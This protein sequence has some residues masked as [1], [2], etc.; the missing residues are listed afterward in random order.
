M[1]NNRRFFVPVDITQLQLENVPEGI[2]DILAE[3][4]AEKEKSQKN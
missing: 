3:I 1:G 4:E 2:E